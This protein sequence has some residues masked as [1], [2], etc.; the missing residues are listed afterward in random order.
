MFFFNKTDYKHIKGTK[1]IKVERVLGRE[2]VL[3]NRVCCRGMAGTGDRYRAGA[4]CS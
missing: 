4:A 3:E 1:G 2:E